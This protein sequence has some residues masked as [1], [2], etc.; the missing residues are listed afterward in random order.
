M[1]SAA[2]MPMAMPS[3]ALDR[4]AGCCWVSVEVK[5]LLLAKEEGHSQAYD[6]RPKRASG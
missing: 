5:N 4:R 2:M 3:G 6:V 1:T